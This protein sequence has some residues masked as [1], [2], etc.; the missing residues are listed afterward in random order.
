M[1]ARADIKLLK[2]AFLLPVAFAQ[3]A[4]I[5]LWF[6]LQLW[7]QLDPPAALPGRRQPP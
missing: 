7:E 1:R 5:L 3:L 2:P 6:L 4:L